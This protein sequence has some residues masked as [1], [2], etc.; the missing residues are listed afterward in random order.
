MACDHESLDLN[1]EAR[2]DFGHLVG[3]ML[4]R[5]LA[6]LVTHEQDPSARGPQDSKTCV[7][8]VTRIGTSWLALS[9]AAKLPL[10]FGTLV[11]MLVRMAAAPRP[12]SAAES[13]RLPPTVTGARPN[14]GLLVTTPK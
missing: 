2:H 12:C 6:H 1:H 7:L 3:M 8:Q 9:L 5:T 13:T 11:E 4:W 14:P 10:F